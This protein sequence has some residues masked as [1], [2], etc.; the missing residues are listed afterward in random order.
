M[1]RAALWV[2]GIT[3][4]AWGVGLLLF[5]EWVL[6]AVGGAKQS[7]PSAYSRY[8]GAWLLGVAA[9]AF[10]SLGDSSKKG[11]LFELCAIGGG[12]SA[13]AQIFDYVRQPDLF[14]TWF[15]WA[16]IANSV[17]ICALSLAARRQT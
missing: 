15:A 8:S 7:I 5:P 16:V 12:L 6:V 3:L 1:V 4:A 2:I 13:V 14:A 9:A 17:L 11:F 10:A